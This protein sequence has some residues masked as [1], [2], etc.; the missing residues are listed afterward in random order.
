MNKEFQKFLSDFKR[1]MNDNGVS[2]NYENITNDEVI[3]SLKED[4]EEIS[5]GDYADTGAN[6][7]WMGPHT[8]G[9]GTEARHTVLVVINGIVLTAIGK[10]V[11]AWALGYSVVC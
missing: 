9:E 3:V 7:R 5:I 2:V 11:A 1:V 6:I 8:I 10:H 4:G